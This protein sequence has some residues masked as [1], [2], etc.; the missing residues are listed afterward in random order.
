MFVDPNFWTL[1]D[2]QTHIEHWLFYDFQ[3]IISTILAK[4][5]I[6]IGILAFIYIEYRYLQSVLAYYMLSG[7][8]KWINAK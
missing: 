6:W 7:C 3:Y 8:N 5:I 4:L 2:V 1:I